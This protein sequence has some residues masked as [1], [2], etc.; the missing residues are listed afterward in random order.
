ML[1]AEWAGMR[2]AVCVVVVVAACS[3]GETT[4]AP[5]SP[6]APSSQL[7][8]PPPSPDAPAASPDAPAASPDAPPASPDG[9]AACVTAAPTIVVSTHTSPPTPPGSQ[10]TF[11]VT[12]VDNDSAACAATELELRTRLDSPSFAIV[13]TSSVPLA[14]GPLQ[15]GAEKRLTIAATPTRDVEGELITIPFDLSVPATGQIIFQ[16]FV[17]LEVAEPTECHVSIPRELMITDPSVVDDP[18]RTGFA[19]P[20]DP[21]TGV[22]T[23]KH[24]VEE[25]APTP[26]DAPAMV[27]AM[28]A[29]FGAEQTINGFVVAPRPGWAQQILAFWPR[30]PGGELDLRAAPVRLN[31]I[32]NRFDLRNLAQGDAGEGRFVFEFLDGDFPVEATIIFEYKLPAANE[33]DALQWAQDFHTVGGIPFSEDYN[34]ALQLLITDVFTRRGARPSGVNGSA[35]SAVRTNE[36]AFGDDGNWELRELA[37]SA[38]TGMLEPRP[39]DLTPD[40]GSNGSERLARFVN[41]NAADI[42]LDRHVVPDVFEGSPFRGGASLNDGSIW[43]A[44]GIVDS[45]ARF[46]FA[47]NTCNGCHGPE[48]GTNFLHIGLRPAGFE[49]HLSGFLSGKTVTNPVTGERRMFNDLARRRDDLLPFVCPPA[50]GTIAPASLR[51]GIG[52]VH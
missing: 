15:P 30:L 7:D 11:D 21:R 1:V 8:A 49:S 45:E 4:D 10:A 3:D 14:T 50:G 47:E 38:A 32:V 12:I 25:M 13:P 23:F 42:L 36:I 16:D 40:L 44:P 9:A 18:V 22:W 41:A 51:R 24:L 27:E 20:S 28:L 37:L 43:T 48:T 6:D 26:A 33:N 46:H 17:Q 29:S 19:D 2:F 35:I 34:D 31:A 5:V 52:R 39:V